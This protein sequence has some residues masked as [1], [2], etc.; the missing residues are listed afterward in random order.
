MLREGEKI[1][2]EIKDSGLNP[3]KVKFQNEIFQDIYCPDI[4]DPA[5]IVYDPESGNIHL[6]PEQ[7]DEARKISKAMMEKLNNLAKNS[8]L[9]EYKPKK[10]GFNRV[11]VFDSFEKCSRLKYLYAFLSIEVNGVTFDVLPFRMEKDKKIVNCEFGAYQFCIE[12][13]KLKSYRLYPKKGDN[14]ICMGDKEIYYTPNL[15]FESCDEEVIKEFLNYVKRN[16]VG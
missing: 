11:P 1:V 9:K 2:Y 4:D 14:R 12:V 7:L 16:V 15:D 3:G 8:L 10:R 13:N 6:F 5:K